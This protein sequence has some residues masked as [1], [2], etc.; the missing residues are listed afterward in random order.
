M[1]YFSGTASHTKIVHAPAEWFGT[2]ANLWLDLGSV[3]NLAEVSV[4]CKPLGILWKA[5]FRV[6]M[7]GALQPGANTIEVKVT[8]LWV[9][10]IVGDQQPGANR[11]YTFTAMEF[12][13]AQSPLLPSG[14]LGPV[15]VLR[16]R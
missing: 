12:Y 4:N 10:R 1:R 5:P 3:K 13:N 6:N 7:T 16:M 15:T 14:L 9:N 2:R 8:N 11:K